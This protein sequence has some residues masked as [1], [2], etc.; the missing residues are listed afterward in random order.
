MRVWC[1]AIIAYWEIGVALDVGCGHFLVQGG[2]S[3]GTA[4][5]CILQ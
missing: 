3:A 1:A 5:Q 2:E 4:F